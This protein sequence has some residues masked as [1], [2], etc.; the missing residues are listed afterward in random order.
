MR[1]ILVRHGESTS[2][3]K[4]LFSGHSQ[5]PL[6]KKGEEQVK[7][8][9]LRLKDEKIDAIYSSDLNRAI[10]TAEAIIKFHPN[11][12]LIQDK[13]I[14][15]FNFGKLEGTPEIPGMKWTEA[16]NKFP[17]L[18]RVE[19]VYNRVKDFLDE[20]YK[21]HKKE[22]VLVSCHG[23]TKRAF[24]TI[25]HNKSISEFNSF[26]PSKNTSISIF[27]IEENGNHK[28]HLMQCVKHLED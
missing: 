2:N 10:Q 6:S 23:G 15:E 22:T 25:I 11:L 13:R 18:E 8:L 1:L 4:K 27:D 28:V 24:L 3:V 20:I 21:K 19:S 17:E 7:K 9:A 16:E 12:R 5:H 14:R 26:K